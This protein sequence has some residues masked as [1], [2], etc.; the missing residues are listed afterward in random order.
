METALNYLDT[1]GRESEVKT[2]LAAFVCCPDPVLGD[3]VLWPEIPGVA[4][5]RPVVSWFNDYG[6]NRMIGPLKG[7]RV[8]PLWLSPSGNTILPWPFCYRDSHAPFPAPSDVEIRPTEECI[9]GSQPKSHTMCLQQSHPLFK[10]EEPSTAERLPGQV[11]PTLMTPVGKRP[12]IGNVMPPMDPF[13][14]G[15]LP[16]ITD[17]R[18][19][20]GGARSVP[21]T[22]SVDNSK[23]NK[24]GLPELTHPYDPLRKDGPGL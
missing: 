23:S 2:A 6:F 17:T 16:S 3:L 7:L 19:R 8:A 22:N 24:P 1:I 12:D 13:R 10:L 5:G 20:G 14:L 4:P 9:L 18:S 21:D 11:Y 15:P